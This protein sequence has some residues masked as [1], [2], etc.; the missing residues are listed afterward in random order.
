MAKQNA[1]CAPTHPMVIFWLGLLTGAI[2][3]GLIFF[4]SLASSDD[5][6]SSLF[7]IFKWNTPVQTLDATTGIDGDNDYLTPV[8]IDKIN[9]KGIDGDNDY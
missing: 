5:Y 1:V 3:V 2:A 7:R 4:G 8:S 6:Q 9:V